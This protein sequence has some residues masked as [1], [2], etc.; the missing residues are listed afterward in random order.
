MY[1][2][3]LR[4]L[5]PQKPKPSIEESMV[6]N[7]IFRMFSGHSDPFSRTLAPVVKQLP[8]LSLI[9]KLECLV[10]DREAEL[11]CRLRQAVIWLL[12]QNTIGSKLEDFGKY[13][14]KFLCI[15]ADFD[16]V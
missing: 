12:D 5:A 13:N 11:L 14:M 9:V 16:V 6:S 1:I 4:Q 3:A 10:H 15:I 7:S 8:K 2:G